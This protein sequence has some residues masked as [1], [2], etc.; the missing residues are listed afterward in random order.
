MGQQLDISIEGSSSKD[1]ERL[2]MIRLKTGVLFGASAACGALA[3]GAF[4]ARIESFFSWGVR[5][6]ECFQALD[7]L[8]DGDRPESERA[9]IEAECRSVFAQLER[10]CRVAPSGLTGCVAKMILMPS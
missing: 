3:A 9:Q 5:V 7:D 6:G 8:D 10:E 4:D 2:E 1:S